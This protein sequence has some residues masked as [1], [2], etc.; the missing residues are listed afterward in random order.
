MGHDDEMSCLKREYLRKRNTI[1][2]AINSNEGSTKDGI[3]DFDFLIPPS[4]YPEHQKSQY[5]LFKLKSFYIIDCTDTD[6]YTEQSGTSSGVATTTINDAGDFYDDGSYSSVGS[7]TDGSGSGATFDGVVVDGEI[8]SV[9]VVDKGSGYV[10][11]DSII[12]DT[13]EV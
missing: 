2:F 5:A 8:T 10:V 4:T 1:S 9:Q 12:L 11:G 6:R 7:T 3:G 13:A